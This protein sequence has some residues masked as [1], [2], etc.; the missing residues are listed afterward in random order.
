MAKEIEFAPDGGKVHVNIEVTGL[1]I[2]SYTLRLWGALSNEDKI[3]Q[4]EIGNN[5]Q[6]H[7]DFYWLRDKS[8]EDEPVVKNDNRFVELLCTA[9]ADKDNV[10]YTIKMIFS[11]GENPDQQTTLGDVEITKK[12]SSS[13]G[14]QHPTL[15]ATLKK[16]S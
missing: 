12:I 10:D 2:V 13:D 16:K 5:K 7:D 8:Q 6:P 1:V 14:G 15:S 11:Q 4:K 3:V 9:H